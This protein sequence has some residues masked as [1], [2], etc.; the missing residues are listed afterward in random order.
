MQNNS[1]LLIQHS[2]APICS[3]SHYGLILI[4]IYCMQ[5]SHLAAISSQYYNSL[6][7]NSPSQ[8]YYL[9]YEHVLP[10]LQTCFFAYK[11]G[12]EVIAYAAGYVLAEALRL[13]HY[14]VT[15]S[16]LNTGC[17]FVYIYSDVLTEILRSLYYHMLCDITFNALSTMCFCM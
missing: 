16:T 7:F 2:T 3:R 10:L 9:Y 12:F 15:I 1:D 14:D 17:F 8:Q 13:L 11:L 5:M 4:V 6:L